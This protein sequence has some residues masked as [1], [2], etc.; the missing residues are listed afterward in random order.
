MNFTALQDSLRT[1][2]ADKIQ[3]GELTGISLAQR[4]GYRQAHISNFLNARRGLTL[5]SMDRVLQVLGISVLELTQPARAELGGGLRSRS[6]AG[7]ENVFLVAAV[8]AIEQQLI[9]PAARMGVLK[10][11]KS[12][13]KQLPTGSR[14]S[15]R[16][17]WMR[18]VAVKVD[19]G[20][21]AAMYPRVVHGSILL[22]DRHYIS[23]MRCRKPIPNIYAINK[24][25]RLLVRYVEMEGSQLLL[26]PHNGRHPLEAIAL[27]TKHL[28]P[29]YIVGRVCHI[30]SEV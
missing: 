21:A 23:L 8:T 24:E 3:K 10:F 7:F 12:F 25:G 16:Q 5:E 17:E 27:D 30:G 2:I 20:N 15:K 29:D 9:S 18:F 28:A 13:L 19:R 26:R 1:K 6:D 11:R 22:I 14:R 4:S